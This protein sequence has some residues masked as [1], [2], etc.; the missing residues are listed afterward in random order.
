MNFAEMLPVFIIMALVMI[1]LPIVLGRLSGKS[2]MEVFF[3]SRVN[4]SAFGGGN[5]AQENKDAGKAE[6][7][8][9]GAEQ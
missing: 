5:Q 8:K 2:P 9:K 3:G 7:G 1:V 4:S 6:K